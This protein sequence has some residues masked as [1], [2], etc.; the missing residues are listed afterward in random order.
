[1]SDPNQPHEAGLLMLD[2]S[3]AIQLLGWKPVLDFNETVHFTADWYARY[4]R[5]DVHTLCQEQIKT[6][7]ELWKSRNEN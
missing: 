6:Y 2:I 7:Q 5:E 1:M 4:A 3:K